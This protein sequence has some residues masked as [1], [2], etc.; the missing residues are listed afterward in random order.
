MEASPSQAAI[1]W[2][3]NV[4]TGGAEPTNPNGAYS[5]VWSAWK[6]V[7]PQLSWALF[8]HPPPHAETHEPLVYGVLLMDRE[9]GR[10]RPSVVQ[11]WR[12]A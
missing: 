7:W 11:L 4:G 12:P 5:L 3:D 8:K 10:D 9:W 6:A 2:Q 1:G